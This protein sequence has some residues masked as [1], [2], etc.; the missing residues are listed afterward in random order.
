MTIG[1]RLV[2]HYRTTPVGVLEATEDGMRFAYT[3]EWLEDRRAFP[4]SVSLPLDAAV[5]PVRSARFFANLL[6]EASVRTLLARRLGL[7]EDN[8]FA[9][10][11]AIGGEC[12]GALVILPE[13]RE[14][15]EDEE[16]YESLTPAKLR[17]LATAYE[18]LPAID[19]TGRARLSLAGAQD[20]LPI[21]IDGSRWLLPIGSSPS[22]HI[23]KFPNRHFKHLPANEVFVAALARRAGLR[24]MPTSWRQVGAEG[25]CVVERYDRVRTDD[26]IER[27]HQEDFCQALGLSHATKYEA[28]GGPSFAAAVELVRDESRDP[29]TDVSRLLDWLAFDVIAGNADGHGKNLALLLR[30]GRRLAPFYDL[31]CTRIYGRIDR[32]LAM[33]VGGERDPDRIRRLH[34]ET[35]ARQIGVKSSL[36]VEVFRGM[37]ARILDETKSAVE[38]SEVAKSPAVE[39]CVPAIRK[40]ARRVLRELGA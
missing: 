24:A 40:Q 9:L 35:C 7:S 30:D 1:E 3:P 19:G 26:G 6:P 38:E 34:L 18:A 25:L 22:T 17:E 21:L 32:R 23:V 39:R 13:G 29:L 11:R 37:A 27:L 8:D 14:V 36:V 5:D 16:E 4:L 20:K 33:S 15:T 2:V 10:L 31:V 28:E 12:A